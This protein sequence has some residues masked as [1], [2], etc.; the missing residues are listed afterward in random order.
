MCLL[1]TPEEA[2]QIRDGLP[3]GAL[4]D[5]VA[6]SVRAEMI[7]KPIPELVVCWPIR[8]VSEE[9]YDAQVAQDVYRA[10]IDVLEHRGEVEWPKRKT[11]RARRL[12]RATSR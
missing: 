11:V 2:A 3:P 4:R 12:A 9:I 8:Q 10:V 5:L 7:A 1:I 6:T